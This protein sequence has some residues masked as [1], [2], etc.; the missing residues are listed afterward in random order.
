MNTFIVGNNKTTS[1]VGGI[2]NEK[3]YREVRTLFYIV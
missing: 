3:R 1:T 2:E